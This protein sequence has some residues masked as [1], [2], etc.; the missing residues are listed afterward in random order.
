MAPTLA[1]IDRRLRALEGAYVRGV[2][3]VTDPITGAV[4]EAV[5]Q[6]ADPTDT[7]I[8]DAQIMPFP[9]CVVVAPPGCSVVV[10]NA[11]SDPVVV[12]GAATPVA[13]ATIAGNA[14][15]LAAIAA[16]GIAIM[17]PLAG[18]GGLVITPAGV[19]VI[20]TLLNNGAA[21]P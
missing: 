3:L 1:D 20:G 13:L 7:P 14:M 6:P 9:G 12:A 11:N 8:L 4:P 19:N 5:V 17:D 2:T 10:M 16:G 21:L 15:V 18:T